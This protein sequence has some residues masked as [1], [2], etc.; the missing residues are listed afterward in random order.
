MDFDSVNSV[1]SCSSLHTCRGYCCLS[2]GRCCNDL[3]AKDRS[4]KLLCGSYV[5]FAKGVDCP[6]RRK[7]HWRQAAF[8]EAVVLLT[9]AATPIRLLT[10][11]ATITAPT[12]RDRIAVLQERAVADSSTSR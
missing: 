9:A 4:H 6:Q 7:V 11:A 5:E 3:H 2:K 8:S 12:A 1:C 10:T